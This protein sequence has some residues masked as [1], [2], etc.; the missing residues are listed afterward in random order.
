M[1]VFATDLEGDEELRDEEEDMSAELEWMELP[2]GPHGFMT[3]TLSRHGAA[4]EALYALLS[5]SSIVEYSTLAVT[6]SALVYL[7]LD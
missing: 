4:F 7:P 6:V 2:S 1:E 3:S 5:F